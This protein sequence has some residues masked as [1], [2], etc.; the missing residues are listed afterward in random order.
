MLRSKAKPLMLVVEMRR[1]AVNRTRIAARAR[2]CQQTP[3][4]SGGQ[5][6]ADFL[7]PRFHEFAHFNQ[8]FDGRPSLRAECVPRGR[9][10][11]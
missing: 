3:A 5:R 6:A 4:Q 8:V 10:A 7:H 11:F 9:A 1:P 2:R